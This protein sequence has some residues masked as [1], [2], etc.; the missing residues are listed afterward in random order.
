MAWL[1]NMNVNEND[2]N[3]L[4]TESLHSSCPSVRYQLNTGLTV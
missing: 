3:Y 4:P 1:W 2:P